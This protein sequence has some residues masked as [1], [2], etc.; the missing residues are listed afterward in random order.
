MTNNLIV[1]HQRPHNLHFR[2]RRIKRH[3]L[4]HQVIGLT[5]E[6]GGEEVVEVGCG[7][8]VGEGVVDGHI[9]E[10]GFHVG[11]EE[12]LDVGVVEG[13]ADEDG[14]DVGFYYIWEAL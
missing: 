1:H 5:S 8:I 3:L 9:V 12:G 7:M 11:V 2:T 13:R 4:R 6:I 10:E 14:A